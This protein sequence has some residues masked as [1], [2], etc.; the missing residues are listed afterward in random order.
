MPKPTS[1]GRHD[2]QVSQEMSQLVRALQSTGPKPPAELAEL[3]GAAYWEKDRFDRAL[4]LA[5][6]DGLV[7]RAADGT[8]N[9]V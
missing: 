6:A 8:I 9:A 2:R 1:E 4:A 7:Y 3:V 5:L